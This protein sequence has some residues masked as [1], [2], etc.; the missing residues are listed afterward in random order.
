[1][2]IENSIEKPADEKESDTLGYE[3]YIELPGDDNDDATDDVYYDDNK[4]KENSDENSEE[5]EDYQTAED[6]NQGDEIQ[7]E[8]AEPLGMNHP[9]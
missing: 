1:M 3:A 7:I 5:T 2:K 6:E 9:V 8:N 4:N